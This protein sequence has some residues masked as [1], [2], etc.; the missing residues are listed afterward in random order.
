MINCLFQSSSPELSLQMK[1]VKKIKNKNNYQII[2]IILFIKIA[3]KLILTN[4]FKNRAKIETKKS[5]HFK[6]KIMKFQKY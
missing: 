1:T 2:L 4:Y 6:N 5:H 3:F